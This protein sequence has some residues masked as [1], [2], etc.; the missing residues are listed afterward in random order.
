MR[1]PRK[2][3]RRRRARIVPILPSRVAAPDSSLYVATTSAN[4]VP[5]FSLPS[6]SSAR[7]HACSRVRVMASGAFF[8]PAYFTST[9]FTLMRSGSAGFRARF[10]SAT[11]RH[12]A[13]ALPGDEGDDAPLD[14]AP[15]HATTRAPARSRDAHGRLL[16]ARRYRRS[17]IHETVSKQTTR[18]RD[19]LS[20][21]V[22]V[23]HGQGAPYRY[24]DMK[25]HHQALAAVFRACCRDKST[26][27]NAN[28]APNELPFWNFQ[29]L[30]FRER[31]D[32]DA[33]S[34]GQLTLLVRFSVNPCLSGAPHG[35][36]VVRG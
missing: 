25:R 33:L 2:G 5:S 19:R 11:A 36:A 7:R 1:H 13:A 9:C 18:N 28:L 22:A 27:D 26:D 24:L 15:P 23:P 16:M 12:C 34:N 20:R 29:A 14:G 17:S 3:V 8:A 31:R 21:R 32:R 6:A 30:T 35:R 4:E 10:A